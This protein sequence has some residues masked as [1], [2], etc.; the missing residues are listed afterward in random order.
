MPQAKTLTPLEIDKVLAHIAS[1]PSAQRPA[2]QGDVFD[3]CMGR[4][5]RQ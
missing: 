3:D 1:K 4:I 2:Q 5:P